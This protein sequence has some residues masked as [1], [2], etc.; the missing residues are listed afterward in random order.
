MFSI[1]C[2]LFFRLLT[3]QY[4]N[5]TQPRMK[6]PIV[7]RRWVLFYLLEM[8]EAMLYHRYV[9]FYYFLLPSWPICLSTNLSLCRW[10]EGYCIVLYYHFYNLHFFI[11]FQTIADTTSY[12]QFPEVPEIDVNNFIL[13]LPPP[14]TQ[15]G[16][17]AP[18]IN[19]ESLQLPP[20]PQVSLP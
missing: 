11:H 20:P 4:T 5:L 7:Y 8:K 15:T 1:S 14:P 9:F 12:F 10:Q 6:A 16:V 2:F 3:T 19:T 18:P 13:D 17:C